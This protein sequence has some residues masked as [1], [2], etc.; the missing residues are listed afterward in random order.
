MA[1]KTVRYDIF[2]IPSGNYYENAPTGTVY[3]YRDKKLNIRYYAKPEQQYKSSP[4]TLA[5]LSLD[6]PVYVAYVIC[7]TTMDVRKYIMPNGKLP[8][9][10]KV[11]SM[12]AIYKRG[13]VSGSTALRFK[14][15][16]NISQEIKLT[17]A[18][19]KKILADV[20]RY[21]W[22]FQGVTVRVSR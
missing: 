11:V 18:V 21:R 6:T 5:S 19:K 4:L 12:T 13:L 7:P 15:I 20:N 8:R 1:L 22:A 10:L 16:D 2:V 17:K 3:I 14:L 9:E